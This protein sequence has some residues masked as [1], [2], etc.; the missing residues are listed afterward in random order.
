MDIPT[1][2]M[3]LVTMGFVGSLGY[4]VFEITSE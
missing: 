4:S 1:I 2:T 3:I